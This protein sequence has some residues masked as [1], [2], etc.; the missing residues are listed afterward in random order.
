MQQHWQKFLADSRTSKS[1]RYIYGQ[2]VLLRDPAMSAVLPVFDPH[3]L[4][5][6]T[7]VLCGFNTC[8]EGRV[9]NT[10]RLL[11]WQNC[12]KGKALGT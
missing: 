12:P 7:S 1:L 6:C 3:I 5:T 2:S 4:C 10:A 9:Y 11:T 8:F